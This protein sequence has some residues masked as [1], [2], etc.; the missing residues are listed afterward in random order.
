MASVAQLSSRKLEAFFSELKGKALTDSV[1]GVYCA[2]LWP[3]TQRPSKVPPRSLSI[4]TAFSW[5]SNWVRSPIS[6]RFAAMICAVF[7]SL[8]L[9]AV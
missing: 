8:S 4:I 5:G 1:E 7:C 6:S 3:S 9:P 2:K